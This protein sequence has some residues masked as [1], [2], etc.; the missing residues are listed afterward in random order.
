MTYS[1]HKSANLPFS[2]YNTL[3]KVR[4]DVHIA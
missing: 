4:H 3:N 1:F 2:R